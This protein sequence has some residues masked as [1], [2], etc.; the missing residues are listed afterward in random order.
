M[1]NAI[2][3]IV[4]RRGGGSHSRLLCRCFG[5]CHL[6]CTANPESSPKAFRETLN[7]SAALAGGVL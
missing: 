1:I 3:L 2:A 5:F 6:L 4:R 7:K